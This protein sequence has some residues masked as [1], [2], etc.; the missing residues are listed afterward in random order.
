MKLNDK[1]YSIIEPDPTLKNN[2][3]AFGFDCGN[4]W[5]PLI[6]EL[7]DKIQAYVDT[8]SEYKDIR[9]TQVKEKWGGLRVYL[10][11]G[12]NE[13]FSLVDEYEEKS[14]SICE[15]C[16]A[17]AETREKNSWLSTLC[18]KH[19]QEWLAQDEKIEPEENE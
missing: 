1:E 11:F 6:F 15:V 8:N 5:Y 2:L 18:E 14:F 16:G 17:H 13:V 10:N 7:L 9:V 3:M 4:G 12:T 19:F